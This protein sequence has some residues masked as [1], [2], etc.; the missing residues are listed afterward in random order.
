MCHLLPVGGLHLTWRF[1]ASFEKAGTHS[2]LS[3]V[4]VLE[5]RATLVETGP[6]EPLPLLSLMMARNE[7]LRM[8]LCAC[9][10]TS[11]HCQAYLGTCFLAQ[12]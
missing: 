2:E 10:L 3:I 7:G 12:S 5:A 4:A 6:F 11:C 8:R 9:V 1:L